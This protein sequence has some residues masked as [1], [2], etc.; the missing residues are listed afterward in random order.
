MVAEWAALHRKELL[1][2]WER[3]RRGRPLRTITPLE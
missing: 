1:D 3:A 2:N